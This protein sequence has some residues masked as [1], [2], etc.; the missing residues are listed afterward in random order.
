MLRGAFLTM[1][2]PDLLQWLSDA[3]KSG[4]LTVAM[5]FEERSLRLADG[6]IVA[7]GADDA[8]QRDLGR[9]LLARGLIDERTLG[10]A[11]DVRTRSSR[12]LAE[13]L[14]AEGLL[15]KTALSEAVMAHAREVTLTLFLWRQGTFAFSE[16]EPPWGA[17]LRGP[18][19]V[20]PDPLETRALLMEGMRRVDEW[21]RITAVFPSEYTQVYA[22]D[23]DRYIPV[24]SKLREI[25]EPVALGE[26]ALLCPQSRYELYEQLYQAQQKGL[27]AIDAGVAQAEPPAARAPVDLLLD[28]ART[29]LGERQFDEANALLRAAEHLDPYRAETRE[30]LRR[31]YDAELADLYQRFPPYKVPAPMG[32][33]ERAREARLGPRERFLLTR[34]SGHTDVA[35]LAVMTPLGELHTLKILERLDRLGLIELQG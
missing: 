9:V 16:G 6:R 3:R 5:E 10:W 7:L 19:L 15:A 31:S 2:L 17:E 33:R 27:L 21:Q 14:A 4:L 13:L 23:D 29:L 28:A 1:P 32:P 18:E 34:I 8:L 12:P 11:L 22:L 35:Q 25:G 24:L 20:L 26:L 30:L